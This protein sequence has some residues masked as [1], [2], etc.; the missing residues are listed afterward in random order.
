MTLITV[1][2]VIGEDARDTLQSAYVHCLDAAGDEFD[3]LK[4]AVGD[5]QQDQQLQSSRVDDLATSIEFN[6]TLIGTLMAFF[7]SLITVVVIFFAFRTKSESLAEARLAADEIMDKKEDE[8]DERIAR[9]ESLL[10]TA[11]SRVSEIEKKWAPIAKQIDER[12]SAEETPLTDAEQDFV[13]EAI[14]RLPRERTATDWRAIAIQYY[15]DKEYLQAAEAFGQEA[16]RREENSN[17]SVA[18]YN[19][20]LSFGMA[21]QPLLAIENYDSLIEW[22]KPFEANDEYVRKQVAMAR[23]NRAATFNADFP[24]KKPDKALEGYRALL[25]WAQPYETVDKNVRETVARTLLNIAN[26]HTLHF[27]DKH[28]EKAI[29]GYDRL[30]EWAQPYE[31]EDAEVRKQVAKAHISSAYAYT[32][33]F[34][35]K[36]PERAIERY[37]QL[38][39]WA[40]PYQAKD[41]AVRKRVLNAYCNLGH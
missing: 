15:Q 5:I 6:G 7:G 20:A 40:R 29:E 32:T 1:A 37:N 14:A 17:I 19:Q 21:K 18:R 9:A 28:P 36:Y 8:F 38:L 24:E 41:E 31:A 33:H 10:E 2:G 35:E 13:I 39:E 25:E 22:A 3:Q 16:S 34:P 11:Q 27:P 30:I 12:D 23:F 26:T 4:C